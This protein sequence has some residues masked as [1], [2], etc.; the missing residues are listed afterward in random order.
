MRNAKIIVMAVCAV[1]VYG[2]VHDQCTVRLC[3]EYFTIAH[4]P[5]FP[6]SS[7]T[8]LGVCWGLASTFWVG[9]GLGFLLALVSQSPGT[10]PVPLAR[11]GR[12]MLELIV[13]TAIAAMLA[14][15]VGFEL[16]RH[17]R[18]SIQN[19]LYDLIPVGHRHRFMAVW[20]AHGASYLVGVGGASLVVLRVWRQRGRPR[21]LA[22]FPRTPAGVLRALA[23]LAIAAVIAW[24][25]FA[26]P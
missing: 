5:L 7:P 26:R 23:L 25:R 6:V 8:L 22:F 21:V 16:S 17:G 11:L 15:V 14:A 12:W 3:P 4:P 1:A 9:L 24:Y 13:V 10:D 19:D 18:V 2:V 20:F